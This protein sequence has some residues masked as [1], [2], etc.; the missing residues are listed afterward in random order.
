MQLDDDPDVAGNTSSREAMEGIHFWM[1]SRTATVAIVV[2]IDLYKT[3]P[4][5]HRGQEERNG[6][7]ACGVVRHVLDEGDMRRFV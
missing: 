1:S 4:I 3:D 5:D 6:K 2:V 7:N